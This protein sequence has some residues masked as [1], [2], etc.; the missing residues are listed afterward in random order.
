MI[1]SDDFFGYTSAI[2]RP[3]AA[4]EDPSTS[5]LRAASERR[6]RQAYEAWDVRHQAWLKEQA[7]RKQA[8]Q[9]EHIAAHIERFRAEQE[10]AYAR[11]GINGAAFDR[12][13]P[14]LLR[15]HQAEAAQADPLADE[16]ARI[17]AQSDYTL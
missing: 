7:D 10:A 16:K 8:I 2:P 4:P 3:P 17:M 13:W 15:A 12:E 9:N 6:A 11:I 14:A 5:A 1:M